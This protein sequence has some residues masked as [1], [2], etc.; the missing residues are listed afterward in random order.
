MLVYEVTATARLTLGCYVVLSHIQSE[1][2]ALLVKHIVRLAAD[3]YL[4]QIVALVVSHLHVE[5]HVGIGRIEI[6]LCQKLN[7]VCAARDSDIVHLARCVGRLEVGLA[8]EHHCRSICRAGVV[9]EIGK[10]LVARLREPVGVESGMVTYSIYATEVGFLEI[11]VQITCHARTV[12]TLLCRELLDAEVACEACRRNVQLA[13]CDAVGIFVIVAV[14]LCHLY[15]HI[16]HAFSGATRH[17]SHEV[18]R[19]A[20]SY[21]SVNNRCAFCASNAV[22]RNYVADLTDVV[23]R[24]VVYLDVSHSRAAYH[25]SYGLERIRLNAVVGEFALYKHLDTHALSAGC[26]LEPRIVCAVLRAPEPYWCA[27]VAFCYC[28]ERIRV[29]FVVA[30]LCVF[31]TCHEFFA[32][33][34]GVRLGECLLVPACYAVLNVGV[35]EHLVRIAVLYLRKE[36]GR[37]TDVSAESE[38][39]AYNLHA[40]IRLQNRFS[41]VDGNLVLARI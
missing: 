38:A 12:R 17:V 16:L 37:L 31:E 2:C 19:L 4:I 27:A 23:R 11:F 18:T 20:A 36:H 22:Y 29:V 41:K 30:I 15:R 25:T 34:D 6:I 1:A 35:C 8:V 5:L 39:D 21:A 14:H 28:R 10:I 26:E 24:I 40:D 32:R 7:V 13:L 33:L 3:G 9:E